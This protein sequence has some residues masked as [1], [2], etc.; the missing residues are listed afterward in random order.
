[1]TEVKIKGKYLKA[2]PVKQI[3]SRVATALVLSFFG[4]RDYVIA[5]LACLSHESRAYI[6]NANG[7]SGF[8]IQA[9]IIDIIRGIPKK[10]VSQQKFANFNL[11]LVTQELEEISCSPKLSESSKN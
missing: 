6:F 4:Y 9:N 10:W 7:L 5:I 2:M 11:S 3:K 8:L 1:M